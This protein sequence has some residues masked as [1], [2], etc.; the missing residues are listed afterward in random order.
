MHA[1]NDISS[2]NTHKPTKEHARIVMTPMPMIDH[3]SMIVIMMMM[4][5]LLMKPRT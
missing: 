2:R 1:R 3:E 4:A 5:S